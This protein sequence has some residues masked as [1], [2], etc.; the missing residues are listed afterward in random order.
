MHIKMINILKRNNGCCHLCGETILVNRPKG[1]SSKVWRQLKPSR[2]HLVPKSNGGL[3]LINN[4]KPS[5][6]GCNSRRGNEPIIFFRMRR[7]LILRYPFF[8]R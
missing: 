8:Y 5:H 2:D 1:M 3:G 4:V 6:A 7:S